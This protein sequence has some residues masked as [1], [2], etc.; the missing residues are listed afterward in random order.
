MVN[1]LFMATKDMFF[2]SMLD[3]FSLTLTKKF[4]TKAKRNILTYWINEPW[5]FQYLPIYYSVSVM[6]QKICALCPCKKEKK[7]KKINSFDSICF[8]MYE[9]VSKLLRNCC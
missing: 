4:A 8:S 3:I 5:L 6:T 7:K 1:R 2:F 9:I